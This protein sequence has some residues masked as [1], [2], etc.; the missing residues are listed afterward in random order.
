MA[1]FG[2]LASPIPDPVPQ[3]HGAASTTDIPVR[4]T[5]D[6]AE[7]KP[8]PDTE[9][10]PD[11]SKPRPNRDGK[12]AADMEP[13]PDAAEK[14]DTDEKPKPDTKPDVDKAEPKV[15]VK[16]IGQVTAN[17]KVST[18]GKSFGKAYL[19]AA[20]SPIKGIPA[21][22]KA[23]YKAGT[24]LGDKLAGKIAGEGLLKSASRVSLK[25]AGRLVPGV[26]TAIGVISAYKNFQQGDYVGAAISMVSAIPG[27]IGWVGIA[28]S[29]AWEAFDLGGNKI[30]QWDSPDGSTTHI[31]PAAAHDIG[32]VTALDSQL[33]EAQQ[34]VFSFQDGPRGQVWDSNP[35]AALRLDDEKVQKEIAEALGGISDLFA[36]VDRVM[37]SAGEAYFD[38]Y[39]SRLQPHLDA[40]AA[41]KEQ[42]KPFTQQLT[43]A[44]DG[45]ATAYTAVLD[46]NRSAREQLSNDSKL[47]DQ[48]PASTFTS[49]VSAAGSQVIAADQNIAA[50]FGESAAVLTAT[51]AS[52]TGTRID[53]SK[54]GTP[55]QTAPSPAAQTPV[56]P[57]SQTPTPSKTETPQ[58]TTSDALGDLL[59]TLNQKQQTPTMPSTPNLGNGLGGGSPLGNTGGSPL[60]SQPS[61]PLSSDGDR[62]LDD[63]KKGD[64]KKEERKLA[65]PKKEKSETKPTLAASKTDNAKA[66][67][68]KLT[69]TDK[70]GAPTAAVPAQPSA[71]AAA[72]NPAAQGQATQP[73]ASKEVDVKGNKTTFPDAKT[74]KM[75][76]LLANA[77]PAHPLSLADA[78]KMA[79]LTPPV[80]GQDPGSQVAPAQAKP[81][82]LLV[83]GDRSYLLLGDGRFYDLTEYKVISADQL[84]QDMG[85]RGGYFHL[86]DPSPNGAPGT[87]PVS[88][89]TAGVEQQV[90][91]GTP[92]P[93]APTDASTP[94]PNDP[95]PG[96]PAPAPAGGVPSASP[97]AP[98]PAA[99]GGPASAEATQTGTGQTSPSP[100]TSAL[101]PAAVR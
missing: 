57:T 17:D 67:E 7:S 66:P 96:A 27:P 51:V 95:A 2:G 13:V 54:K 4:G 98:K 8:E 18:I 24:A 74:A 76:Q 86:N 83:A 45:A 78:A 29:A 101:D 70:P 81:G 11:E 3:P 43:A 55:V 65:E 62:K 48:G 6:A 59:R 41:L 72:A 90:P 73:E 68:S 40:M 14:P 89:Q 20:K 46:A 99:G 58:K 37:S 16:D 36:E 15:N 21:I 97:G 82:D 23:E 38:E 85:S 9:S 64:E 92:P 75:A 77:D 33:R 31:L 22:V 93:A 25:T 19:E 35:P 61:K 52:G 84:P 5:P 60:N 91:G 32:G 71:A 69:T 34:L 87:Q 12:V 53:P 26:G 49:A 63:S 10:K 80:P 1:Q 30:G 28:A 79:G 56:T 100:S 39:R 88:G 42:V 94:K 44:S 50:L 47:S